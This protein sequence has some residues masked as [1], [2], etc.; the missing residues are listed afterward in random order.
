MTPEGLARTHAAAFGGNGWPE[1]DFTNYLNDPT[2]LISG[3]DFCF[4]VFRMVGPEAEVLTLATCPD[5]QN[6]GRATAMMARAL[7]Q[8]KAR[9]VEDVFLDVAEDNTPARALYAR[10]GFVQ[11]AIRNN[12][13]ASGAAA[14]CMKNELSVASPS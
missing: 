11:F 10:C 1:T 12:Y 14:I 8:L 13:Y 9:G 2:I 7:N 6:T 4:G 5:A 3:D